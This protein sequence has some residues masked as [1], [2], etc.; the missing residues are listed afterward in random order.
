MSKQVRN[1]TNQRYVSRF[2][3]KKRIRRTLGGSVEVPRMNVF[4][5]DNH[6]IVQFIDDVAGHTM[7]QCSTMQKELKGKIKANVEGAKKMG[8]FCAEAAGKK[9]IKKVVFDRNGYKYHGSMKALADSA[10]EAGLEF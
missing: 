1:V 9:N 10:R 6:F 3:R 4:R 8:K 7:L 2:H 5:S